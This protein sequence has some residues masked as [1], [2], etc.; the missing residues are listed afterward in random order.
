MRGCFSSLAMIVFWLLRVAG[1]IATVVALV[2]LIF[3]WNWTSFWQWFIIAL[4]FGIAQFI[5][6]ALVGK[7]LLGDNG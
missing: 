4:V 2:N 1:G 3:L 7:L 6:G 5:W